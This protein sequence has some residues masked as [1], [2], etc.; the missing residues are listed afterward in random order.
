MSYC[1]KVNMTPQDRTRIFC[2]V[3]AVRNKPGSHVKLCSACVC[4]LYRIQVCVCATDLACPTV[5]VKAHVAAEELVLRVSA[6]WAHRVRGP[7]LM[8]RESWR[9]PFQ[10]SVRGELC[11]AH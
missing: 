5:A 3:K 7:G 4:I 9:E 10:C 2:Q 6:F 11:V 8:L 1:L